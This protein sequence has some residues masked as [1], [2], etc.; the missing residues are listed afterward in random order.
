ML[1]T[2]HRTKIHFPLVPNDPQDGGRAVA[3]L[4]A[5]R[6]ATGPLNTLQVAAGTI[7]VQKG[8]RKKQHRSIS[9]RML[10]SRYT[11]STGEGMVRVQVQMQVQG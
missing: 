6:A 4:A 9:R 10:L 2:V 8:S 5:E 3:K 7:Q 11:V 1:N